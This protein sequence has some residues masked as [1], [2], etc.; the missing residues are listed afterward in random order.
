M[1]PTLRTMLNLEVFRRT[2]ATVLAGHNNLDRTVRWVHAGEIADIARFLSGGEM[3]LTAGLG[4]GDTVHEQ[5]DF[6]RRVADADAAGLVI[7]LAGRA[8]TAMPEPVIAEADN[9]GLP[10]IGLRDEI[11]FVEVSA[12]VHEMLVDARVQELTAE[13]AINQAFM[14][15][16]LAG[17]DYLSMTE[18]LARRIGHPVVLE[19]ITH[20][21][22][23]YAGRTE[24]SDAVTTEWETHSRALHQPS[25]T[26]L[27]DHREATVKT[28]SE[29]TPGDCSRRPVVLR[30]ESWGSLHVLH[31]TAELSSVDM[32]C[33]DRASSAIAITLL[34]ERA[35]GAR[36]AQRHGA[37]INR[38]MLGDISG[39]EFVAKALN[40]GRDLRGR[41]LAV[42][43]ASKDGQDGP[44]TE[45]DLSTAVRHSSLP[46]VVAD[47]G[48]DTLAVIGL[49]DGG[50]D[51]ELVSLLSHY[52]ARAG[53]SRIVAG[54]R[55]PTAVRQARNAR[56]A[57][58]P[59]QPVLRFD[60]LGVLRL[61]V[62]L[63]QGPELAH[64]VEDELG[65]LLQH[66]A[67]SANPLLPTL[68]AYLTHDGNKSH[69]ADALFVQRRTLYYR[70]ERLSALL[71]AS[72]DD[73]EVRQRLLLAV[74]GHELLHRPTID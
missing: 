25:P 32:Y 33:L 69:A 30:G 71:G 4:M 73:P 8:F 68:Y 59:G 65:D 55:L 63:A 15:L 14:N 16:L 18:E 24:D 70:L 53:L 20:Q 3:L 34:G 50:S 49:P 66:D 22:L 42:V 21:I 2:Q 9:L 48:D 35:S 46:A 43:I 17:E 54:S 23:A 11:P 31:G 19:D 40:L 37:L 67:T 72:L 12:Q 7:E 58:R 47:I 38:L 52:H 56:A 29:S 26:S 5:C 62:A 74:R 27:P 45:R 1:S 10:L 64:Y 61:L 36:A 60:E 28:S 44:F 39:E 13:E 57:I 6:I 51:T 41:D